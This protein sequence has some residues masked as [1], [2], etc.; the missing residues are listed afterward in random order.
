MRIK[1]VGIITYHHY[2]NYGTMLQAYALQKACELLGYQ[3]E[4]IDFKQN[5]DLTGKELLKIRIKRLPAYIRE[6]KKYSTLAA[7]K[8]KFSE[9]RKAYEEFY[10]KFLKVGSCRYTNSKELND[11]PPI[12][13]G[14]IV[15][16]DQTWNPYVG[17]NPEAF[18]LSFVHDD[19]KKG[20][21][22]PSLAVSQL[23]YEQKNR[24]R[25]RLL[26]FSYLS[27]REAIGA[28]L[29]EETLGRP[30]VNV[31]DPTLLL[32]ADE[33]NKISTV[34][35][36]EEPYILTYF[37]GD[38]KIHRRFVHRLADKTGLKVIAIPVSY[39]D[40]I[41]PISEK[42]WVG[43]DQFLSLISNAEY[44]CTDSFHGTMFS[45]I[46]R[47]NF[48]SFCKT[49]DDVQ[50]SENSRLY[51]ALDLFDLSSR[52]VNEKNEDE[53]INT[54]PGIEYDK[55]YK[56][57]NKERDNSIAYLKEMLAAITE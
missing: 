12:Y 56:L 43:P 15:G 53:L 50:S 28:K 2:Y 49:K 38:V 14:Y 17:N 33:W 24:F 30:I 47:I 10:A 48:F 18:Y 55:S 22:A 29:L 39:L 27:C 34:Q 16:S 52:L 45:I 6:H 3:S 31:L 44:V 37:L 25:E 8:E 46:Y 40:I 7:F 32:N 13:D 21:Y 1:S 9:R 5:N 26:G 42:R 20:S 57:L 41:D 35:H 4:I 36:K 23:T 51:S 11:N 19:K 54:L